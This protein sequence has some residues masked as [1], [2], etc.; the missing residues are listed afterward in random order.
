MLLSGCYSRSVV[1]D[2]ALLKA[3]HSQSSNIL[4][5]SYV[6]R[7]GDQLKLWVIEYPE[8]DT[9]AVITEAG[10]IPVRLV[11][12]IRLE[13]L[14]KNQAIDLVREKISVYVRSA[15]LNVGMT[16]LTG[17]SAKLV[18]LGAV[19][20]QDTF[21][22]AAPV[23]LLEALAASGGTTPESDLK[24][25][26]V[27]RRNS[28]AAPIEVD[29]TRYFATGNINEV[30]TI[31]PGDIVYVPREENFIR[32]FSGYLR[33]TLFLFGLFSISR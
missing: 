32:E 33:D 14:T 5:G 21:A 17:M 3:A 27:Y 31:G 9:T 11:G 6:L 24:R 18:M 29:L 23:T 1:Q 28:A 8:F 26:K 12:D 2:E 30:P 25:I 7:Q 13:G 15:R 20:R 4:S 10:T 19:A 22:L 16:V